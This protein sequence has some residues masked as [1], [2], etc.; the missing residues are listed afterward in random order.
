M[1]TAV[2]CGSPLPRTTGSVVEPAPA[3]AWPRR[4]RQ[5]ARVQAP[6]PPPSPQSN[7][8]P[9]S[10]PAP[11]AQP[12]PPNAGRNAGSD[13]HL[14]HSSVRSKDS[15]YRVTTWMLAVAVFLVIRLQLVPSIHDVSASLQLSPLVRNIIGG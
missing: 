15:S 2:P 3:V 1:E 6:E 4:S 12:L 8:R 11:D 13:V 5:A 9:H 14:P 10:S 7:R